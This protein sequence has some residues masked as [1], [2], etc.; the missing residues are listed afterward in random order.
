MG[1]PAY[2]SPEQARDAKVADTRDDIYSLGASFYECLTGEPP[3]QGETPY[4]IMSELL[5]KPSPIP[6]AV[7]PTISRSADLIC[8]KMMAK[9]RDLRYP[10]ARA[11]L[12]DLQHAQTY[13]DSGLDRLDAASFDHD[14]VLAHQ[15]ESSYGIETSADGVYT[16]SESSVDSS[17][18]AKLPQPVYLPPSHRGNR[19]VFSAAALLIVLVVV[20]TLLLAW[21]GTHHPLSTLRSEFATLTGQPIPVAPKPAKE[22]EKPQTAS[23][24]PAVHAD[25]PEPTSHPTPSPKPIAIVTPAPPAAL[26]VPPVPDAIPVAPVALPTNLPPDTNLAPDSP[27]PA[28]AV[29]PDSA[30]AARDIAEKALDPALILPGTG[31]AELLKI[32]GKRDENL[33][34]PATWTFYFY[35][36][37]AAGHARIVTVNGG[38]VVKSGEDLVDFASPYSEEAVLPEDKIEK[39]SADVLQIA[40]GLLPGI[41]VTSSE[42][43]LSQPKNSDPIWKVLLWSKSA[44]GDDHKLGDATLRADTG[45]PVSIN[46]K[47]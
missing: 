11:L 43:T 13:G 44:K 24:K 31:R 4:N 47:P 41:T 21:A 9:T 32:V 18:P 7:R 19:D 3:F 45:I 23:T 12:Q 30:F 35:D 15:K 5:T 42:F 8:R 20:T 17:G 27:I 46:L 29:I 39:D 40:E 38:K 37:A 25:S 36:K 26:P 33:I 28:Q 1:T 2:M 16:G 22:K 34:T 6:S 14:A 10:D